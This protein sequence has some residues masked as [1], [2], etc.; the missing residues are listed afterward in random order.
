[1]NKLIAMTALAALL[2][3]PAL[4]QTTLSDITAKGG[5]VTIDLSKTLTIDNSITVDK[6]KT[7]TTIDKSKTI[8][9]TTTTDDS[10]HSKISDIS[11]SAAAINSAGANVQ[12]SNNTGDVTVRGHMDNSSPSITTTGNTASL[13]AVMSISATGASNT[14]STTTIRGTR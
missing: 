11:K 14:V 9:T 8:T 7:E 3:T 13:T 6:S 1:M 12:A 4:A 10:V 5:D 2:S